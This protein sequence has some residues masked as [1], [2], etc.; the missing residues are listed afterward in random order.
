[1]P[2]KKCPQRAVLFEA[3]RVATNLYSD[4]VKLLRGA[5]EA[6][7]KVAYERSELARQKMIAARDNLNIHLAAHHCV[8]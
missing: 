7:Y 6:D 1:M 2:F 8:Q 3:Y 5:F 4:A